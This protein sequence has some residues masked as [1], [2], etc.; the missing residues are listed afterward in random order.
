MHSGLVDQEEVFDGGH[1]EVW[2]A[3]KISN[4]SKA[5]KGESTTGNVH[6][7]LETDLEI[8]R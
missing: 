8:N 2:L 6:R 7:R 3:T 1:Y 5:N 4:S